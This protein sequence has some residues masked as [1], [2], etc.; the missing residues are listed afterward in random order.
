MVASDVS[1]GITP[2][3][4]A[5]NKRA[6]AARTETLGLTAVVFPLAVRIGGG[7]ALKRRRQTAGGRDSGQ[8]DPKAWASK[9]NSASV[10]G[11]AV[12]DSRQS[13][14][15]RQP[16]RQRRRSCRVAAGPG[17][18]GRFYSFPSR[19]ETLPAIARTLS[20][21][22]GMRAPSAL[23]AAMVTLTAATVLS[24]LSMM[25]A[26]TQMPPGMISWLSTA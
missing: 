1:Q 24:A 11:L 2:V 25:G 7:Q 16:E 9:A 22:T 8:A 3:T 6:F 10:F 18:A 19:R 20:M 17:R 12:A 23:V 5:A 4:G 15:M 26:A 14:S 21:S 13:S